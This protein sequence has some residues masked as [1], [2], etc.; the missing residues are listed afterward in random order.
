MDEH[1]ARNKN[2]DEYNKTA[3]AYEE[4]SNTN[5]LMQN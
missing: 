1:E 4:W 2:K 5:M 3:A